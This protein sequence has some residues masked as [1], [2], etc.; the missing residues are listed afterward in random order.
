MKVIKY[1]IFY[2]VLV[3]TFFKVPVPVPQRW[4]RYLWW[5]RV[6]HWWRGISSDGPRSPQPQ[7]LRLRQSTCNIYSY[8]NAFHLPTNFPFRPTMVQLPYLALAESSVFNLQETEKPTGP[9]ERASQISKN[10][11][12]DPDPDW[13]FGSSGSRS[14]LG[15]WIRIQIQAQRNCPKFI[16]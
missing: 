14:K 3:P 15:V 11:V 16:K 8:M 2:L 1:K 13:W 12:V 6:L 4:V 7:T 5:Q 9:P 10:I